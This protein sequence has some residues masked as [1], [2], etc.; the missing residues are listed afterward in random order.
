MLPNGLPILARRWPAR[1]WRS[2]PAPSCRSSLEFTKKVQGLGPAI[3]FLFFA[4]AGNILA[5]VYTGGVIGMDLAFARLFL[6]L[7]FGIGIGMIMALIFSREDIAR[8][9]ES[10][11]MFA[12]QGKMR[13]AALVFLLILVAL[14]LAGTFKVGLADQ[15]LHP[16]HSSHCRNG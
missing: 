9:K 4:P 3:T 12:G 10:D 8:D 1:C 2:V 11:A 16:D 14:L 15:F 13:R 6:S 5:L 7:T